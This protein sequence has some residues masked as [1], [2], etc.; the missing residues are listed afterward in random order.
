MRLPQ[1]RTGHAFSLHRSGR[2]VVI[3]GEGAAV[4]AQLRGYL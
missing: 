1:H 4:I 3:P 2:H